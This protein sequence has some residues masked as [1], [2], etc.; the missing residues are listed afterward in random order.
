MAEPIIECVAVTV[1][2]DA[3]AVLSSIDLSVARGAVTTI[4]GGSGSGKST[5]LKAMVGLLRP[6]AGTVRLFGQD[7]YAAPEAERALLR[8]RIGMLFQQGALFGSM[9][10]LDN[11]MLPLR[12]L[13]D[14]PDPIMTEMAHT[15]L[16]LVDVPELASRR[17]AEISGGQRKRVALARASILD[18]EVVFCDEPTSGLDPIVADSIDRTLLRLRDALG[19]TIVAVTHDVAS[20]RRIADRCVMLGGGGILA[21]SPAE[22]LDRIPDPRVRA[23]FARESSPGGPAV[24]EGGLLD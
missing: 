21:D 9:N 17:P 23:F 15:R 12:E 24:R 16:A 14:L 11:V 2:Y 4:V 1:G 20:V 6:Q 5:L 18:P 7:L 19:I 13:T 22:A 10:V 8:R 3:S